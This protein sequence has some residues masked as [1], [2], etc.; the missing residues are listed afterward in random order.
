MFGRGRRGEAPVIQVAYVPT[1]FLFRDRY[2][3][4]LDLIVRNG[5]GVVARISELILSR[6]LSIANITTPGLV[7][8]D[9]DKGRLLILVEDCDDACGSSLAEALRKELRD[10]VLS[11]DHYT[12]FNS[13]VF[14]RNT[15][16]YFA[17]ERAYV[18]TQGALKEGVREM[19][20]QLSANPGLESQVHNVL[21]SLG[22]G[23]GVHL[24][25]EW[26][27]RVEDAGGF[28]KYVEQG[29]RFLEAVYSALGLGVVKASTSDY[30]NYRVEITDNWECSALREA[31]I[32]APS[33]VTLGIIEGYLGKMLG[34]RVAA[35]EEKHAGAP[36]EACVFT[37]TA[38]E[39][40]TD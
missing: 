8:R 22:K 23:I 15:I 19:Y 7:T 24:Y 31:G 2:F 10:I 20:R 34:R 4:L 30:V 40:L 35:S 36:G 26:N 16:L 12:A 37:A 6:G 3:T 25:V 39:S 18:F 33:S 5:K 14:L 28:E 32:Q 1:G 38:L 17:H 13:Y 21:R 9:M 29:L 27:G 11:V